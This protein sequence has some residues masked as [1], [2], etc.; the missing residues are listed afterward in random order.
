M[1]VHTAL[2][3]PFSAT[4]LT[5]TSAVFIMVLAIRKYMGMTCTPES[6]RIP[7]QNEAN[8]DSHVP[9]TGNELR[10]LQENGNICRLAN[11]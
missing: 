10:P 3:R 2:M 5:P 11:L 4:S 6:H 8:A 9:F 7:L 1:Y